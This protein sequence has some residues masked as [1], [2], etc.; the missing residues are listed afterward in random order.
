L[1]IDR[2]SNKAHKRGFDQCRID[3]HAAAVLLA[4]AAAAPLGR[5]C[6][7]GQRLVA[8]EELS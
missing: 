2:G 3:P 5:V 7:P 6:A 8:E 4:P 1:D